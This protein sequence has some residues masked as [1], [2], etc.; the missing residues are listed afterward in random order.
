[1]IAGYLDLSAYIGLGAFIA[2]W[3]CV[4]YSVSF[5]LQA[6]HERRFAHYFIKE[7][8]RALGHCG[9][10]GVGRAEGAPAPAESG[11]G[12]D[13]RVHDRLPVS[14]GAQW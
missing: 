14:S 7:D 2:L 5:R 4:G 8:W 11:S 9:C 10:C 12:A 6:T 1:M 13:P 3:F